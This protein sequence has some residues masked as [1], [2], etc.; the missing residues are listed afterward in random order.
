MEDK[1]KLDPE[2]GEIVCEKCDG[3]G[4]RRAKDG[5]SLME[6][7]PKCGGTGKLDWVE[8]VTGKRKD[9]PMVDVRRALIDVM[10]SKI[11]EDVDRQILAGL[12]MEGQIGFK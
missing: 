12:T 4:T 3:K 6:F 2:K 8:V 1:L 10:G 7:C 9:P 11:A 5:I